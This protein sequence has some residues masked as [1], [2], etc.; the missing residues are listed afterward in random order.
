MPG[1]LLDAIMLELKD[2]HKHFTLASKRGVLQAVDGLS[3]NLNAGKTLALVGESGCGKSTLARLI[4]RTL[5]ITSGSIIF[6]GEDIGKIS[7]QK[8][9]KHPKRR[10]IQMVFQDALGSL[11]PS[12]HVF[13][14]IAEPLRRLSPN[15]NI[16][17]EVAAALQAVGLPESY[18]FRYPHQLSGGQLARVGIARAI[19]LKPKLLVLDEPTAALDVSVQAVVL[20]T[21]AKLR[22]EMKIAMLFVSH[23]LNIVRLLCDDVMVMY[24]GKV[25]EVG[26]AQEVFSSAKHPYTKALIASIPSAERR[27]AGLGVQTNLMKDVEPQSPINPSASRCRFFGRC[28]VGVEQCATAM[29]ALRDLGQRSV[30]CHLAN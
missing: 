1:A 3:L 8:M 5:D 6:D 18:M 23:D 10:D 15:L 20:Q 2:V 7:S 9:A 13:D 21:L 17:A 22:D 29:P 4:T 30:S 24:M 25:M 19:I 11:N 26:S 12:F 27:L 28:A 16:K 14:A